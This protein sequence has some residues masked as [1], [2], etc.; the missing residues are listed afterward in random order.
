MQLTQQ[1][2]RDPSKRSDA[3]RQ[4]ARARAPGLKRRYEAQ[5]TGARAAVRWA[6]SQI[7][8]HEK[9]ANSDWGHPVQDWILF[10]GYGGPVFWCGCFVA[11]AVVK[12]GGA[13]VPHRIRLG[14]HY[15]IIE[16]ARGGR[17]GFER[18]VSV[19]HAKP[20]D[21]ATFQF[22]TGGHIGL[23]VGPMK[24]GMIHTIDGNT[25]ASNGTDLHGGEVAEHR[26]PVSLVTCVG[27]LHY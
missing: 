24:N 14:S 6:R 3:D 8:K 16:D 23:V 2:I 27:R 17:N 21:I 13:D 5:R 4:R 22:S 11:F 26:R 18:A 7:G 1:V 20:G 12:K 19:N 10:T 25:T 9:P 15:D